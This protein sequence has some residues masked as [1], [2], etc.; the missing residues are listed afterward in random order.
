MFKFNPYEIMM[1]D[2][3]KVWED[4]D[5]NSLVYIHLSCDKYEP[6]LMEKDELSG[7]FTLLR[8]VPPG[9]VDYYFSIGQPPLMA[10]AMTSFTKSFISKKVLNIPGTD[11]IKNVI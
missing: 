10:Q 2:G 9:E 8:M 7:E 3:R 11:I 4:M 6:D 1:E 5:E